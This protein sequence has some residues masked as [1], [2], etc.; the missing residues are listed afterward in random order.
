MNE[1]SIS[2]V[3]LLVDNNGTTTLTVNLTVTGNI[4]N[5]TTLDKTSLTL[6]PAS[7]SIVTI[8]FS[9]YG[10]PPGVVYLGEVLLQ[11]NNKTLH[12]PASLIVLSKLEKLLDVRVTIPQ[13]SGEV[14]P[15][16]MVVA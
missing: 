16:G 1:S 14:Y 4:A 12:V 7:V 10:S 8:Q 2:F 6:N 13:E 11:Y 5:W 3:P 15:G 9:S